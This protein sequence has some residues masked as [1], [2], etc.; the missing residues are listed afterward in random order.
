MTFVKLQRGVLLSSLA[1]PDGTI[2]WEVDYDGKPEIYNNTVNKLW[3]SGDAVARTNILG[4]S[5]V[6][7][8]QLN[9]NFLNPNSGAYY[10]YIDVDIPSQDFEV[11]TTNG[12][13]TPPIGLIYNSGTTGAALSAPTIASR[14]GTIP[15]TYDEGTLAYTG[16]LSVDGDFDIKTLIIESGSDHGVNWTGEVASRF[17]NTISFASVGFLKNLTWEPISKQS[18]MIGR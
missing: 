13:I 1:D 8:A 6:T 11:Y 18:T 4:F 2:S 15:L 12:L 9:Q 16:R 7:G 3:S 17:E 14:S 5:Y 10:D